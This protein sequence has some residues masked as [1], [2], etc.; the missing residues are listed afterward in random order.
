MAEGTRSLDLPE[1]KARSWMR[2]SQWPRQVGLYAITLWMV[3][4]INFFL[5]RAMPGDP[6]RA[7]MDPE[8]DRFV[9]DAGWR[10]EMER[11]YGLDRPLWQQYL[12]YLSNLARGDLGRSISFGLPVAELIAAHLPWTLLL[13]GTAIVLSN[14]LSLLLGTHSAWHRGSAAD[15]GLLA[16]CTLLNTL[17]VFFFGALLLMFF[18]V[19]LDWLPVGG[20]R[21]P[22]A[23]FDTGWEELGDLLAHLALPLAALTLG[24]AGR[25]YLLA[26]NSMVGVL[27]QEFMLVARGKGLPVRAQ[28]YRHGMRN[29]LLP[30]VTRFSMQMGAAVTGAVLIETLFAYPG[31]GRLMFNAVAARDYAVLEGCFL[32][33]GLVT[34]LANLAADLSY[35]WLD[36][37]TRR[38][39]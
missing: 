11:Y 32:V 1:R 22:F 10:A 17:P 5:P 23:S 18:A 16:A 13:M 19:R 30:V 37:R 38:Q 7:L 29:A 12:G 6:L 3:L 4:T 28:K 15:R 26:R 2:S 35:A 34:L 27:G 36:P 8:S 9:V 39:S 20:G 21:T 33:A 14:A 25:N 31:M 24:L